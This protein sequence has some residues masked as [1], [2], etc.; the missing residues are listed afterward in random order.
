VVRKSTIDA[1]GPDNVF[2]E[3]AGE[4][5]DVPYRGNPENNENPR[6]GRKF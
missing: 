4:F 5:K 6:G 2:Y 1:R 3:G